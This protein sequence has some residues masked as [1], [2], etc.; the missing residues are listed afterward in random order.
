MITKLKKQKRNVGNQTVLKSKN[1][2]FLLA[3]RRR[4]PKG[5]WGSCKS[6]GCSGFIDQG[7]GNNSCGNCKHHFTQHR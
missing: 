2:I 6:C 7:P 5:G 1:G 3:V 4:M